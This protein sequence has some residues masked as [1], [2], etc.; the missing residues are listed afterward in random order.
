MDVVHL[1][2]T[3]KHRTRKEGEL[4]TQPARSRDLT[5]DLARGW[6]VAVQ[7]SAKADAPPT[8]RRATR[9]ESKSD[10]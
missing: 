10:E 6:A 1:R 9:R 7:A 5:L 2:A 8:K 3:A 4:Y